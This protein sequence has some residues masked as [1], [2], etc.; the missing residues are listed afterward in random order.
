M[1][2]NE[3][4]LILCISYFITTVCKAKKKR[5]KTEAVLRYAIVYLKPPKLKI[6]ITW[7]CNGEFCALSRNTLTWGFN[8]ELSIFLENYFTSV[9]RKKMQLNKSW[10]KLVAI[11]KTVGTQKRKKEII[12]NC[13][14]QVTKYTHYK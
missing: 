6:F 1:L 13:F 14:S 12:L 10:P 8:S 4:M 5:N 7:N 11:F 3:E 2:K 9:S